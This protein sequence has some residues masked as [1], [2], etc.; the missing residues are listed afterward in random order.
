[1]GGM[2][3]G[4]EGEASVCVVRLSVPDMPSIRPQY[5]DTRLSV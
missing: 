5:R 4:L 3:G 2:G 1:M